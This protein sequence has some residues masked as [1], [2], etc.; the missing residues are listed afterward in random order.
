[1]PFPHRTWL[2]P[3]STVN[4][5]NNNNNNNWIPQA[6]R[7]LQT[8]YIISPS[9]ISDMF[10]TRILIVAFAL[11]LSAF[12]VSAAPTGIRSIIRPHHEAIH[13]LNKHHMPRSVDGA[14]I[15]GVAQVVNVAQ[16]SEALVDTGADV[17]VLSE[18]PVIREATHKFEWA[19]QQAIVP[20]P[21]AVAEQGVFSEIV[22]IFLNPS[23]PT[24]SGQTHGKRRRVARRRHP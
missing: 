14:A 22:R 11:A 3:S 16:G 9:D 13:I 2:S 6:S 21:P 18:V 12:T 20:K 8:V 19:P 7:L 1:M 5:N 4:N 23:S 24:A 10:F 17:P 15:G